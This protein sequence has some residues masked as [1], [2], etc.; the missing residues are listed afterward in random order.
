MGDDR[1]TGSPGHLTGTIAGAIVDTDHAVEVFAQVTHHALDDRGFVKQRDDHHAA[2]LFHPALRRPHTGH[3]IIVPEM[4]ALGV[5]V[6]IIR[7]GGASRA[8]PLRK[9]KPS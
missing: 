5:A 2:G 6:G 4:A 7:L 9:R 3:A 1:G 8:G